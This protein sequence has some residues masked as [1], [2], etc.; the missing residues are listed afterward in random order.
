MPSSCYQL[1]AQDCT[2]HLKF[3]VL[4]QKDSAD[5]YQ[6]NVKIGTMCVFRI[7]QLQSLKGI[8]YNTL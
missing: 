2:D 4:L 7:S 6:I 8:N 1:L 5:R 3:I